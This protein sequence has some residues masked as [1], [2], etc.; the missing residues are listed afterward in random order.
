MTARN[1]FIDSQITQNTILSST[2]VVHGFDERMNVGLWCIN[3]FDPLVCMPLLKADQVEY[4]NLTKNK[5]NDELIASKRSLLCI[6]LIC[7][8][9]IIKVSNEKLELMMGKEK[10]K[11]N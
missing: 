4:L 8:D 11:E 1:M 3:H 6:L 9:C 2:Q 5:H 7:S 10:N